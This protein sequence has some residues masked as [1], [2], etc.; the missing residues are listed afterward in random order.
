MR[1]MRGL[2]G[3]E[4]GGIMEAGA[5]YLFL[6]SPLLTS[7]ASATTHSVKCATPA[8]AARWTAILIASGLKSNPTT[9]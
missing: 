6:K 1:R 7:S 5:S 2:V 4:G 9:L 8:A 3:G